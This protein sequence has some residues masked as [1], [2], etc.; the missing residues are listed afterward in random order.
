MNWLSD[1]TQKEHNQTLDCIADIVVYTQTVHIMNCKNKMKWQ[2]LKL[3]SACADK[4]SE[5]WTETK[6][7][8]ISKYHSWKE[9]TSI[10]NAVTG[11]HT[12]NPN[13]VYCITLQSISL[14]HAQ[15]SGRG[16]SEQEIHAYTYISITKYICTTIQYIGLIV[17]QKNYITFLK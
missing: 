2:L 11:I 9:K 8:N 3:S 15:S 4:A 7:V 6:N 14:A 13:C 1:A 5:S 12:A 10:P 17:F 16:L